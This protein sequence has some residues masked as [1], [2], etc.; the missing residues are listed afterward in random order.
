MEDHWVL[1]IELPL[2]VEFVAIVAGVASFLIPVT[3]ISLDVPMRVRGLYWESK[4][5]VCLTMKSLYI[6]ILSIHKLFTHLLPWNNITSVA[7][8]PNMANELMIMRGLSEK[9]K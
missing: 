5:D 3:F 8:N 9:S 7:P 4:S 2:C 6:L 1:S